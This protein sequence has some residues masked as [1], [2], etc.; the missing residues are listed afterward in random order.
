MNVILFGE[1]LLACLFCSIFIWQSIF[2]YTYIRS[3]LLGIYMITSEFVK[4]I[5]NL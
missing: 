3:W 4:T 1:I 2:G 5:G